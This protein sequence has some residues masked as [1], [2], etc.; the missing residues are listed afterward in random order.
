MQAFGQPVNTYYDLA[1]ANVVVSLDSD[2]LASGRGQPALRAPVRGAA[3][4]AR[5][6]RPR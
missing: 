5:T 3:A 2:F 1:N 6:I 4:R